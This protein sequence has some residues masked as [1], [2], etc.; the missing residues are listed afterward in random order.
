[1]P[2]RAPRVLLAFDFGLRRIGIAAGNTISEAATPLGAALATPAGPDWPTIDRHL[3]HYQPDL[4]IV[5]RP[6]NVDGSIGTLESAA[7]EFAAALALRAGRP[8][9]RIDERYS[10]LEAS[11]ALRQERSAGTRGR[12]QRADIDGQAAAILLERYLRG[13]REGS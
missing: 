4:L 12:I 13:E 3:A 8:V 10:S 1:M 6:Y 9:A 11:A 7:A 2:E 5:G